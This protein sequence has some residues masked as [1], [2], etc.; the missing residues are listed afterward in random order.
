MKIKEIIKEYIPP[1]FAIF[2]LYALLSYFGIGCPIKYITGISCPG[3]G[4]TR[5]LISLLKLDINKAFYFHPLFPLVIIF[6]IVYC[7]KSKVNYKYYKCFIFIIVILFLIIYTYRL[8]DI[9]DTIVVFKPN[10]GLIAR[11]L[12]SLF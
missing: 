2:V 12:H 4:M 7:F 6:L 5:A 1:L 10:D 3:C 9:N 8:L 11:I